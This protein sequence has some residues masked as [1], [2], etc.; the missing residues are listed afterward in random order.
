M[1]LRLSLWCAALALVSFLAL[2]SIQDAQAN[3]ITDRLSSPFRQAR[4][5]LMNFRDRRR[6]GRGPPL[7]EGL[8]GARR[9]PPPAP[10]SYGMGD[11]LKALSVRAS[12]RNLDE[13]DFEE[14]LDDNNHSGLD[15]GNQEDYAMCVFSRGP[16]MKRAPAVFYF[17]PSMRAHK[18]C[19]ALVEIALTSSD[20]Y[21]SLDKDL[22]E[23]NIRDKL[24]DSGLYDGSRPTYLLIHGFL[25]SW[26]S[27]WMCDAKDLILDNV[28]ANVFIVDWSGGAKP[29][30]PID[31]GASV[32]NT[33]YVANLLSEF[34]QLLLL[35]SGQSDAGKFH[36]I[37]H[38]LG[39]HISGFIGY[40]VGSVN[41]IMALDPA[42][43]CFTAKSQAESES[44]EDTGL[45]HKAKRRLS[46]ESANFV[47]ALHTD[48]T[49]FGL[50]ENCA[51]Y[52]VYVNGGIKQPK[53]G[54]T[55]PSSRFMDLIKLNFKNAFDF[56]IACA[57]SYAHNLLD[58]FINFM[59]TGPTRDQRGNTQQAVTGLKDERCYPMAYECYDWVSFKSGECGYCG[60]ED[61]HCLF[62]GLSLNQVR[63]KKPEGESEYELSGEAARARKKADHDDS[64]F[65]DEDDET[66]DDDPD[67]PGELDI[68]PTERNKR[69][70]HFIRSGA[71]MKTCLFH[72]QIIVAA[73]KSQL[74][75]LRDSSKYFYYLNIPLEESGVLND[76]SGRR[77]QDRLV[78]VS[79]RI[80]PNSIAY[81]HLKRDYLAS[82]RAQNPRGTKSNKFDQQN[83]DIDFFSALITFKQA[84]EEDCSSDD[85]TNGAARKDKWQL[86]DTLN[87][88]QEA[89]LWSSSER[90]LDAVQWV[91][92]NFMSGLYHA[93]R[94][95]KSYLLDRDSREAVK[96]R[97][98]VERGYQADL[99]SL[100]PDKSKSF[101]NA[102][103]KAGTGVGCFLSLL[104]FTDTA[105]VK[106]NFK[107]KRSSSELKYAI[108][109]RPI[110]LRVPRD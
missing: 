69:G 79:H 57:H 29:M 107:C 47:L 15:Q 105:H 102:I 98:E 65:N 12:S 77:K 78:Q 86:C 103:N 39:A 56:N 28:D 22:A 50:N 93:Q 99:N 3:S 104:D 42:G 83:Q 44:A 46:P 52:D 7:A 48:T 34:I 100:E 76:E 27:N 68:K 5:K 67:G 63:V 14:P 18:G 11:D 106:R 110:K 2:T 72:Y 101:G 53:C 1:R 66:G 64:D 33:Q 45:L 89:L 61:S 71:G 95:S 9:V 60:D 94:V 40:N 82:V 49:L 36:L 51:H 24:I 41:E 90:K 85:E 91:S 8:R 92:M 32:S 81:N 38:S 17:D 21:R 74:E 96:S 26:K 30:V 73:S 37:G 88:V 75:A 25:A 13:D 70:Q 20:N 87:N 23:E 84:P 31:Y 62:T 10:N 35:M 80:E 6:D 19:K 55:S 59:D 109:L 58:T 43:P 4:R 16:S 108:K 97:E 54:A